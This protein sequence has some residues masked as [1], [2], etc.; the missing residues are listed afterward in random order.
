M[1]CTFSKSDIVLGT[2]ST[3]KTSGRVNMSIG[4]EEKSCSYLCTILCMEDME[5]PHKL[6]SYKT[7]LEAPM[8]ITN[9]KI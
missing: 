5:K 8:V 6:R 9:Y 4:S 7:N 1:N 3:S 2:H